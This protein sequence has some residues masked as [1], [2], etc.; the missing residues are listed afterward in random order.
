LKGGLKKVHS[1]FPIRLPNSRSRALDDRPVTPS[2]GFFRN[3]SNLVIFSALRGSSRVDR[4]LPQP[5]I[6]T[7]GGI[8]IAG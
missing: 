4:E 6:E 5:R 1:G 2:A 7:A 8:L 3:L